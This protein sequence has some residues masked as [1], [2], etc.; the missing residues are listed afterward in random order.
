MKPQ[1]SRVA[2]H[3]NPR[4]QSPSPSAGRSGSSLAQCSKCDDELFIQVISFPPEDWR[5]SPIQTAC[6]DGTALMRR[7]AATASCL[8][9]EKRGKL[10]LVVDSYQSFGDLRPLPS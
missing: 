7:S 3:V 2:S 5:L 8:Q 6:L 10:E 4:S 9:M 1:L